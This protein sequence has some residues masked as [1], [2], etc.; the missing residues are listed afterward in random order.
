MTAHED[1]VREAAASEGATTRADRSEGLSDAATVDA[2]VK[3]ASAVAEEDRPAAVRVFEHGACECPTAENLWIAYTRFLS[4]SEDTV[5]LVDPEDACR[6]AM[7]NCPYSVELV[8]ER[9]RA[10][11][12]ADSATDVDLLARLPNAAKEA[13]EAR[14][15]PSAEAYLDVHAEVARAMRRRLCRLVADNSG[16][17]TDAL[18]VS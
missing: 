2:Y 12:E 15:L 16:N 13:T 4:E 17:D 18:C 9:M 14:F 10:I 7:R 3:Y 5:L 1:A 11:A 8:R 6:R